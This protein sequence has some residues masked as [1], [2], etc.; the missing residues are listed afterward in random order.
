[1]KAT[2]QLSL[3]SSQKAQG[4]IKSIGGAHLGDVCID[5]GGTSINL[6]NGR[7]FLFWAMSLREGARELGLNLE[8]S[9]M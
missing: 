7:S 9:W 3:V 4:S 6:L 8:V 5:G 2:V 1:M